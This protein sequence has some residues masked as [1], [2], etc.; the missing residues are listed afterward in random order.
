M[1][2]RPSLHLVV[3]TLALVAMHDIA[4]AQPSATAVLTDAG[5]SASDVHSA[6]GGELVSADAPP[7]S[8]RDLSV[9]MAFLVKTSPEDLSR[10]IMAGALAGTDPQVR[11][12][13][14]FSNPGS[15]ADL[16]GLQIAPDVARA[17]LQAKPGEALNLAGTEIAAFNAL[18]GAADP[19]QAARAQLHSMLL[20]RLQAYRASGLNGIAPYAR[21]GGA[22]TNVGNELR[23][24]STALRVLA[25]YLPAF[26][27]VLVGYPTTTLPGMREEFYWVDYDID[28][29]ATYALTHVLSAADGAGRVVAQREYY[30]STGYN[31]EQAVAGLLPVQEGTLVAY[32]NHTFTD[33]IAGL[34]GSMKRRIGQHLMADKLTTLFEQERSRLAK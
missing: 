2:S 3:A 12:H 8:E 20:A 17:F 31:C 34:G 14:A 25:K 22:D 24:A 10:H 9:A 6:L 28:G 23:E 27:A 13:G 4:A 5:F 19:A 29:T 26:Q 7:A 30:V 21:G 11:A 16:S 32:V 1:T 18:Q 15:V 33:Q